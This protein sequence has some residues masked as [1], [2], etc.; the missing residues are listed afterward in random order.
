[1]SPR[2]GRAP[3]RALL[4][5]VL[6]RVQSVFRT[7]SRYLLLLALLVFV[8]IGFAETLMEEEVDADE[9]GP[10][11]VVVA[12]SAIVG[13]LAG[14]VFYSGAVAG[15]IA[16]TPP[17]VR[18][19]IVRVARELPWLRLTAAMVLVMLAIVIGFVALIVPG[20]LFLAWFAF[21]APVIEIEGRGVRD[22]FRRSRELVK[23]RFWLVLATVLAVTLGSEAA[24]AGMVG[25]SHALLGEGIVA[26]WLAEAGGEV[27]TNPP[28]AVTVVLL[29]VEIMRERGEAPE[30]A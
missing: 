26:T 24:I 19:S 27:I 6:R 22:G 28:Y 30:H 17:G 25:L 15:L 11:F 3:S 16:K 4:A 20:V 2:P 7:D 14:E 29:A 8:P 5:T 18:P 13:A 9:I 1:M 12:I 10:A 21:V 23:D